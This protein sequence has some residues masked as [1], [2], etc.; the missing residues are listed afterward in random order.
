MNQEFKNGIEID[1]LVYESIEKYVN[2]I[3]KRFGAAIKRVI[4]FGSY[5]KG[6]AGPD[7]DVDIMVITSQIPYAFEYEIMSMGYDL[8]LEMGILLSVKIR[9]EEDFEKNQ[10]FMFIQSVIH[11]GLAVG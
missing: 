11:E 6:T 10:N 4:L 5:A 2:R 3:R 1:P 9:N 7:S 8:Y